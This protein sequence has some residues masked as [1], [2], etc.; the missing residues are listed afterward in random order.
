MAGL[1]LILT[2]VAASMMGSDEGMPVGLMVAL[3]AIGAPFLLAGLIWYG[4]AV[5]VREPEPVQPVQ[6]QQYYPPQV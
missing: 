4:L 2:V 1:G 5:T 3:I 6:Q